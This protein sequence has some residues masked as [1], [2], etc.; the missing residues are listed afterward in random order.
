MDVADACHASGIRT[1]AVTAGYIHAAPRKALFSKMDAANVDLKAFTQSFYASTCSGDLQT[2]LDTLV[3]IKHRTNCWLEITTLL[4][5]GA[6]DSD[7]E[8]TAL[9]Q[10]VMRE[11]GPDV[12]LHFSAFH[13]DYKMLDKPATPPE[14]LIRARRIAMDQ[15]LRYVYTGNVHDASGGT[16]HC[17]NCQHPVIQRDWYHI[18]RYALRG[19]QCPSCGTTIAGHFDTAV[20][21]NDKGEFVQFGR[22]RIPV[23]F[24]QPALAA[25]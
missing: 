15:G 10:W 24:N 8:V 13:P 5:P 22:Q 1:V 7:T 20:P 18:E 9:S 19:N 6:N 11:L 2:V 3:Y 25:P 21:F 4:I 14:T 16:T 12:P 17:P 23:Q